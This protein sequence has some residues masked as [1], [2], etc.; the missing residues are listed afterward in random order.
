MAQL[1]R[2][3]AVAVFIQLSYDLHKTDTG[4]VVFASPYFRTVFG[5]TPSIQAFEG[6]L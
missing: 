1:C 6:R 4:V 5:S 2:A 3:L